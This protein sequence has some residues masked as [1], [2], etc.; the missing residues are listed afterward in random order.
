M[1]DVLR[2]GQ[3]WLI[4]FVVIGIGGVFV[5][6][7]GLQGPLRGAA[8]GTIVQVGPY[9]YGI[10]EFERARAQSLEDV[11]RRL[12]D[13]FDSE[14]LGPTLDQMAARTLVDRALLAME[15][16]EFGL[17]VSKEEIERLVLADPGFKDEGGRFDLER[18]EDF[19]EYEY[20]SQN[21]FIEDR[22]QALLAFKMIRL[23]NSQP[24]VSEGEARTALKRQLES[25][26]I[27]F[28]ALGDEEPDP[29]AID[30]EA[31]AKA[32]A[33][34]GDELRALYDQ[35]SKEFNAG[36]S[37]RARHILFSLGSGEEESVEQAAL[38]KAKQT[39]E[40]I[41]AGE[42]FADLA[43]ELSE[44]VGSKEQGGDLGF[45]ERGQMVKAFEE[46]AFALEPGTVSEPIRSPFGYHLI[47]VE[48]RREPMHR[49]FEEVQ[50]ELARDLVGRDLVAAA[51]REKAK[52][53]S[54]AV[55][56]GKSLEDAA[57]DMELT[58]ERSGF[59]TRRPDGFVPGLG[60]V[61]DLMATAF[62]MEPGES[63][64]RIFELDELV[65][66]VEVLERKPAPEGSL[67]EQVEP[68]RRQLLQAK[69]NAWTD[70][71]V[72]ARREQLVASG[73][74]LVDLPE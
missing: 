13:D 38:E 62:S 71:W 56:S 9:Q 52:Q 55:R 34:R 1:L 32:I 47:K 21:A 60:A 2:S 11:R 35:R 22:R 51:A 40:R 5:F 12:G 7:L 23:L 66:L 58:L 33:E 26:R 39:L 44:D 67:E 43:R 31:V 42:D 17:S 15:A 70:T 36:E 72:N 28:V 10:R 74:L 6:F 20:G 54:E 30:D 53:L 65:A 25:V 41:R 64:P 48:E 29:D 24:R 14:A 18:F 57:R 45:F 63:S 73:D 4:W 49:T 19:A 8:G 37:V 46:A 59:L 69:R 27:A 50:E 61:P 16:Q 3:R 68:L